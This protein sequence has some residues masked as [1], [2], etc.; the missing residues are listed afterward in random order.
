[1]F[2]ILNIKMYNYK[3]K[4]SFLVHTFNISRLK[5]LVLIL[6][7]YIVYPRKA[8]YNTMREINFS[9]FRDI[10]LQA[11]FGGKSSPEKI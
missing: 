7:L 9:R 2:Y 10:Y 1:M 4:T 8:V 11:L 6:L 5:K 3:I